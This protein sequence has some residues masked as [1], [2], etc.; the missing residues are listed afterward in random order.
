M[1]V[2]EAVQRLMEACLKAGS[3]A[4]VLKVEGLVDAGQR[5][6][7]ELKLKGALAELRVS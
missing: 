2:G 1:L 6:A 7:D 5:K 4:L 3:V